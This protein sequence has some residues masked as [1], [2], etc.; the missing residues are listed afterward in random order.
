MCVVPPIWCDLVNIV[1]KPWLSY[2]TAIFEYI[3]T[4]SLTVSNFSDYVVALI[5][6]SV[7][8]IHNK[9]IA[10][11]DI[12]LANILFVKNKRG[13][14]QTKLIE[15]IEAVLMRTPLPKIGRMWV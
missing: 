14:Y 6:S 11:C 15:S 2:F 8:F 7:K 10:H 9:H 13:I 1:C 12:R 4:A 5:E 3:E